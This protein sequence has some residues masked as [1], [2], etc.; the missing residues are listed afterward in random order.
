MKNLLLI[1]IL[2]MFAGNLFGQDSEPTEEKFQNT[3][4]Y[5]ISNP[6]IF[7]I[8]N[9]IF[10]Y[11]RVLKK[12][13]S[14]SID[15]GLNQ[16]PGFNSEGNNSQ[17]ESLVLLGGG[18]NRGVHFSADYRFYLKSENKFDAP[19]GVYIGPYYSFN[20]FDK[21]KN[22]MLTSDNF[23]GEVETELGFRIH[24]IGAELGYQFQLS[25]RFMLDFVLFGPGVGIYKS[26]VDFESTLDPDDEAL[27]LQKINDLLSEKIPGFNTIVDGS[28]FE[29]TGIANVTGL[30]YR[31]MINVGYRF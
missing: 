11:E 5:N 3:L 8:K 1:F 6:A 14:F 21:S 16:L 17:N 27:I 25:K 18:K 10:G 7:G 4:R 19:R 13:R 24:T 20:S 2:T 28:G 26:K 30:G 22:W 9:I 31:F 29:N 12:N 15:I 23:E